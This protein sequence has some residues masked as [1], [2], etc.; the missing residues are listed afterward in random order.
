[1]V[2]ISVSWG[3]GLNFL[4]YWEIQ[5]TAFGLSFCS[6][7]HPFSI[8]SNPSVGSRG[9]S[10]CSSFPRINITPSYNNKMSATAFLFFLRYRPLQWVKEVDLFSASWFTALQLPADWIKDFT[11]GT[12]WILLAQLDPTKW[13]ERA[14][15]RQNLRLHKYKKRSH[16]RR[17]EPSNRA[18]G[19]RQLWPHNKSMQGVTSVFK[20]VCHLFSDVCSAK[21][22][23]H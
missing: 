17:S 10:F 19:V 20:R 18:T 9:G 1:M 15:N 6:S 23:A 22:S 8:R 2:I 3:V 14:D 4:R 7:I 11:L 5:F 21:A 13:P 16:G 12:T